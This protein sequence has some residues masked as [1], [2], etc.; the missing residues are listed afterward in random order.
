MTRLGS[1]WSW[2]CCRPFLDDGCGWTFL[3]YA[4]R[5][6]KQ[7]CS[8]QESVWP[9]PVY[10]PHC[11]LDVSTPDHFSVPNPFETVPGVIKQIALDAISVVAYGG[12]VPVEPLLMPYVCE[13]GASGYC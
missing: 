3:S 6:R 4:E 1:M 5:S 9:K 12:K 11:R 13:K 10:I 2:L 7:W 8:R